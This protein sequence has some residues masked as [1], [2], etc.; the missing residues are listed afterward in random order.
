MDTSQPAREM[1]KHIISIAE[2]L[3]KEVVAEGAESQEQLERL[4]EFGCHYAQGYLIAKP[5]P[6]EELIAF[7]EARR[8]TPQTLMHANK[9]PPYPAA[10]RST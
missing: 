8:A 4:T 3:N 1:V 6:A 10:H 9:R 2:T 7:L 5:M